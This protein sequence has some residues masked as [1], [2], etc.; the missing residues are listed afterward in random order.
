MESFYLFILSLFE[1]R[2]QENSV[3]KEPFVSKEK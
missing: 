2:I 1:K 3:H